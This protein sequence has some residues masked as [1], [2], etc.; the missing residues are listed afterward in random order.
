VKPGLRRF[1][2]AAASRASVVGSRL[3]ESCGKG[4]ILSMHGIH[5]SRS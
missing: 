4:R 1:V 5:D 3:R 2:H